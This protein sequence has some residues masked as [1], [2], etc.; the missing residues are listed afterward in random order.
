MTSLRAIDEDS[1]PEVDMS[2]V[3]RQVWLI[4]VPKY[5]AKRMERAQPMQEIG[6]IQTLVKPSEKSPQI[7]FNILQELADIPV[8]DNESDKENATEIPIEHKF[9]VSRLDN[10]SMVLFSED[11]ETRVVSLEGRVTQKG[12]CRPV[13]STNLIAM[14]QLRAKRATQPS[15]RVKQLDR[16]IT[17][18]KPVSKPTIKKEEPIRKVKLDRDQLKDTVF[19]AFEK[20]QYYHLKDLQLLTGQ[21][22]YYLK[23]VVR[24]LCDYNTKAPNKYL[25]ELK[26]EFRHYSNDGTND[27]GWA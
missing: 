21:P 19:R 5:L 25:W 1:I 7:V 9:S 18:F 23:A 15:R 20:H 27:R 4:K 10:Q 3:T 17:V 8:M 14:N 13:M 2:G 26:P 11:R 24:E 22:L 16:T 6:R 12:D